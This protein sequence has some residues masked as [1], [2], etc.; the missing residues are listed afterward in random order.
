MSLAA[1]HRDMRDVF[2]ELFQ[3]DQERPAIRTAGI[4]ALQRLVPVA[5]RDSGQSGVI[6]RFLLGL[7]NGQ[8]FPFDLTELRRLDLGLFDDCL[9]VLRLDNT[10]EQ[11]VHTYLPNGDAIWSEFRERWA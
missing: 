5:Q 8:S 11:E 4:E 2:D 1:T 9:A 7:Y 3:V 10:P 6:G